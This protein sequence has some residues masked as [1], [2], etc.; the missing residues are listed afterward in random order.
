VR[1][2]GAPADSV[3]TTPPHR[4]TKR[5]VVAQRV[6]TIV[7]VA[8]VAWYLWTQ[9]R[10]ASAARLRIEFRLPWLLAASALVFATYLFLIELWRRVLAS[11]GSR[12]SFA[13]AARIWFVSNL[14]KYVPGKVWQITTMAAML[15]RV[16]VNLS[17]AG[18]ASALITIANIVAGFAV[19]LVAGV[20]AMN[21][22]SGDLRTAVTVAT[23]VLL[24]LLIVAAFAMPR[25]SRVAS[26]L[27]RR[28]IVLTLPLRAVVLSIV[29]CALAWLAYGTA[30]QLL[31][32]SL[33]G[34]ASQPWINYV[35]AYTL[36]YLVGYLVL[37]APGGIGARE[38]V[39]TTMLVALHMATP[40]EAT[41][42]TIV[43][44][45]WLTILEV[46]P[47]AVFLFVRPKRG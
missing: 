19:L 22:L 23:V 2:L 14:G 8:F 34:H 1:E 32:L 43:S 17:T 39:L 10:D 33:L 4:A 36:S 25:A 35:G 21:V 45:L 20:G 31:V 11:Y 38:A 27:L 37:V 40:A 41:V 18:S 24:V 5:W 6:F 46:L 28:D 26:R 29:G 9:W 30:F 42:I 44:R 7:L 3:A 12:I 47:G 15:N 16:G 13:E